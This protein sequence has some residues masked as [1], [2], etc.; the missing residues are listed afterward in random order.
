MKLAIAALLTG[1]AAAFSPSA[2]K[3]SSNALM[4]SYE[5]ELGVQPPLGFFVSFL[6]NRCDLFFLSFAALMIFTRC[7]FLIDYRI[8]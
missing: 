6:Y 7:I 4:M 3:V 1:S 2:N 5:S 8:L